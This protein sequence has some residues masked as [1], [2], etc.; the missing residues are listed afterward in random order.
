MA[1]IIQKVPYEV[2]MINVEIFDDNPG[3]KESRR[4]YSGNFANY[5]LIKF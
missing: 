2:G 1:P 4:F 5:I 3:Y